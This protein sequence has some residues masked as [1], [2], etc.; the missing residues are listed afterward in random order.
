MEPRLSFVTLGVSNLERSV[1]FYE[2]CLRL[3]RLPSDKSIAFF[4]L[5][6][7]WLAL[8]PREA[9]AADVG[10]PAESSGF[11][12]FTLAHNVHSV[13]EVDR[14]VAEIEAGGGRVAKRPCA[15]EWGGYSGYVADPDGYFWEIAYNPHFPHT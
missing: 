15:A 7:L 9:L 3:P 12:G 5:G 8:Y 11:V 10:V 4:E 6:R 2:K 14:L 13:K 1:R